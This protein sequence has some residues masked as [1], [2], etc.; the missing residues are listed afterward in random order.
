MAKILDDLSRTFSEY[1]L[2][3]RLTRRDNIPR[4][5][6]L[7]APIARFKAGEASR[8]NLNIPIVSASMQAV[9]GTDMGIALA[10]QGGVAFV[11]CSQT[12]EAQA[13]MIAK[14]KSH[15]AGF[16][17]S[18]SNVKPGASLSELLELMERTG[19]STVAVTDDGT[20]TGRFMGIITDKDFWE[21]EDDLTSK[22][23]GYMTPRE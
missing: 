4:N 17:R 20:S 10:R 21:F 9:S 22:V 8:L 23:Q 7:A 1:L 3:P 13:A 19:H 6:S 11:F 2:I 14:I 16:V 15:K 5:V 12:I 18:D